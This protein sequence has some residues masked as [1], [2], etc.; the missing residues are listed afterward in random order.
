MNGGEGLAFLFI[1]VFMGFRMT[2]MGSLTEGVWFGND[3]WFFG[4][5]TDRGT[6]FPCWAVWWGGVVVCGLAVG[7]GKRNVRRFAFGS[8]FPCVKVVP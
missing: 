8:I 6:A 2:W 1:F 5:N 7:C 4:L 3:V